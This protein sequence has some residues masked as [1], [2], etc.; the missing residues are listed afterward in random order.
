MKF[1]NEAD[2]TTKI[3]NEL[4]LTSVGSLSALMRL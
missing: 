1:F 2:D 3:V 4:N